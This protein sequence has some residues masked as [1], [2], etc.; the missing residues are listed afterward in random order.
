MSA[1]RALIRASLALLLAYALAFAPALAQAAR[2]SVSTSSDAM[3]AL[4]LTLPDGS[5]TAPAK[6]S[7]DQS[8]EDCCLA[9]CRLAPAAT[10]VA[11]AALP[12]RAFG[13]IRASQPLPLARGHVPLRCETPPATGPPDRI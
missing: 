11:S 2:G 10:P 3:G 9:G 5:D 1:P 12:A 13:L 4:C 8:H 6:G 7:G